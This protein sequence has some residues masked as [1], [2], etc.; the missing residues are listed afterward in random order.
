MWRRHATKV[1][2]AEE[3]IFG[4][5]YRRGLGCNL[6][7]QHPFK[8]GAEAGV[9]GTWTDFYWEPPGYVVMIDGPL[10]LKRRQEDKDKLIDEALRGLGLRVERFRYRPPLRKGRLVEICDSIEEGLKTLN[11]ELR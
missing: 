1:S 9:E 7:T 3:A 8:F 10:H 4:E 11:S 2:R 6:H 5:L